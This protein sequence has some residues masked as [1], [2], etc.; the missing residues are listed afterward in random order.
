MA[1]KIVWSE[2]AHRDRISILQF[3]IEHNKSKNFSKKLNILFREAVKLVAKFPKT[4]KKTD[5]ENIRAKFVRDYL[6]FYEETQRTI[7]VLSIA[8]GRQNPETIERTLT[9]SARR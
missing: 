7:N 4:G 9:E 6:I 5:L 3:W 2:K 1:K 8:D